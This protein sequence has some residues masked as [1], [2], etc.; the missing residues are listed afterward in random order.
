[1]KPKFNMTR[2]QNIFVAKRNIV[3]Y[4][5]K[6]AK[7]EGLGVTYP[8]TEA[9]F[10]GVSASGVKVSD[11]VAVNN[12][13]HAWQFLLDTLDVPLDYAYLCK[14]NQLVGGDSLIYNA[15]Y[16][17]SLPVTIGGTSW[18][19][20]MPVEDNIKAR[21]TDFQAI[22]NP[23]ERAI[24]VMLYCMRGQFFLDGNKRTS[25]LAANQIMIASGGGIISIPEDLI[26]DFTQL[27]VDFYET[28]D[29]KAIAQFVYDNCIDGMAFTN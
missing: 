6:S 26:R 10:N 13:K 22:E 4:I 2:E 27:L 29:K 14:L 1:M 12:L 8:D 20:D 28:D 11:I 5:Y 23:T 7:L 21:L 24:E 15:G 3:D 19:P 17:R 9:I 18:K 16:I 25:M